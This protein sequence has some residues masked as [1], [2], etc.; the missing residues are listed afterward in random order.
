MQSDD[1]QACN[2]QPNR[3]YVYTTKE[4]PR[5]RPLTEAVAARAKREGCTGPACDTDVLQAKLGLA[6]LEWKSVTCNL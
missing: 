6:K 3:T 5:F 4:G 2:A 1:R